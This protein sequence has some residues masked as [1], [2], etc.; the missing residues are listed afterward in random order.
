MSEVG[1]FVVGVP[2]AGTTWLTN[3]LSQHPGVVLSNPKEPNV[4][5]SHRGT[6]GR[7]G[8]EPDWSR[9]DDCF[10]G[11]GLRIDASVHA[12]AC[13]LAPE[14]IARRMPSA[15]MVLCLREPV[16]RAVSHW[17][18]IRDTEE[19]FRNGA[20]WSDFEVAWSDSRLCDD[21]FYGAAMQRW[22]E[23]FPL[24]SFLII[25]SQ[26]MRSE[27]NAVL[28]EV[29]E[30]LGLDSNQYDLDPAKHANRASDR[31]PLTGVG[32]LVRAGF[33]LVPGFVKGPIVSRLQAR[34]INI[35]AAPVMSRKAASY[36]AGQEHYAV[37]G[38]GLCEDLRLFE[39]LTGF[40]TEHWI[41]RIETSRR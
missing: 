10:S 1:A 25:D 2:K 31:R 34:D 37:C 29:E 4:V 30:F 5:A 19:D 36:S 6:F 22:L 35:Y 39:S 32:R 27:P 7:T 17:K 16:S 24:E 33:S 3:V 8:D 23:H 12:F 15:P 20:D 40:A 21:S 26:R 18:M 28:S 14:R 13:P 38:E 41:D 9:Y 11:D